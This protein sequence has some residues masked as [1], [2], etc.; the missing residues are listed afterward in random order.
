MWLNSYIVFLFIYHL[1]DMKLESVIQ[2]IISI[3]LVFSFI[4]NKENGKMGD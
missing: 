3:T 2:F 4:N 1:V